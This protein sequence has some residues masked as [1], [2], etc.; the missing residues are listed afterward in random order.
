[1]NVSRTSENPSALQQVLLS[2]RKLNRE[3]LMFNAAA[4]ESLGLNVTDGECIDY[5][6][7]H[8][9]LTAGNL[10]KL[11]GL[12]NGA[13]TNVIDRLEKAGYVRRKDHPTDRRVVLVELVPEKF[14]KSFDLYQTHVGKIVALL[15]KYSEDELRFLAEVNNQ[16]VEIY[17]AEAA[18][19]R[20]RKKKTKP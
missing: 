12:T 13:I 1:M 17:I 18:D 20:G 16:L 14:K 10:A 5:L 15:S 4:A 6:M 19:I 2:L 3:S 7:D 9:P 11:T 8:G